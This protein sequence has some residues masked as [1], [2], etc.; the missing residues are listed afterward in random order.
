MNKVEEEWFESHF[1]LSN[2]KLLKIYHNLPNQINAAFQNWLARTA[3][4]TEKSF[5]K[6]INDKR[7]RGMTDHVAYTE[8]EY[9][10]MTIGDLQT[11]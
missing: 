6:Y 11:K 2:G 9:L 5:C 7:E 3:T 10:N 8:E 1:K 4:F